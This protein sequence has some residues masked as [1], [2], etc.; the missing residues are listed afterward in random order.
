MSESIATFQIVW[1]RVRDIPFHELSLSEARLVLISML[2]QANYDLLILDEPMFSLGMAQ[3]WKL[4]ESLEKTLRLKYL[5]LITHD[6]KE[7]DA[8][9]DVSLRI[10]EGEL[11][12]SSI[13]SYA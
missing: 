13:K 8:L 11:S 5:I 2:C 12:V 3:R 10:H 7:A 6:E 4:M 9:C 1:E